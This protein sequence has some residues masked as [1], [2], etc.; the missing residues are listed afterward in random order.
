M[1]P[2]SVDGSGG[3]A[4]GDA[5]S[6]EWKR[7]P[8]TSRWLRLPIY[9]AVALLVGPFLATLVVVGWVLVRSGDVE[10]LLV[11]VVAAAVAVGLWN[12]GAL[13]AVRGEA[14]IPLHEDTET[15]SRRALAGSALLGAVGTSAFL[16]AVPEAVPVVLGVGVGC[17]LLGVVLRTEGR[18]DATTLEVGSR[19]VSLSTLGGVRRI[20]MGPRVWFWLSY[21]DGAGG[22][23]A[24]RFVSVPASLAAAVETSLD[25]GVETASDG[26]GDALDPTV[27]AVAILVGLGCL[28][29]GPALWLV[30]PSDAG[31]VVLAYGATFGLLF[32]GLL[33]W[34]GL[35]G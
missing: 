12:R 25:A 26:D 28:A 9:A 4:G 33:L 13:L 34:Y 35:I 17:L 3:D 15:L 14:S 22:P 30:L 32:G 29:V 19:D 7:S 8:A 1:V 18:V 24:P 20:R 27:R 21:E 16:V 10:R 5:E 2:D 31:Q 11:V 6:V 23:T